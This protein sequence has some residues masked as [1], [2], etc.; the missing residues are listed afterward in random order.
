LECDDG[1]VHEITSSV[2]Q[3]TAQ[4]AMLF[5][6]LRARL[7]GV[8]LRSPVAGLRL[9][10][11][12][13]EDGGLQMTLFSGSDPDPDAL[14]IAIARLDAALGE[15]H[16]LRA[17]VVDGPRIERRFVFEPFTLEVLT[18]KPPRAVPAVSALPDT[19]TFQYRI[20]AP[21]PIDVTLGAGLPRFVGSPAQAVLDVAGPWRIDE[22]WWTPATG[23]GV[24]LARDE[25]DV[26][27][28]DG[29]LLRGAD[30]LAGIPGVLIH[31]RHDMGGPL[32]TAWELARAWPDAELVAVEDAGHTGS[33]TMRER[34]RSA[35]DK[36]ARQ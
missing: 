10:A 11:E 22:G 33:D 2:A 5:E 7:E 3:P 13:L 20:V 12:R 15:R 34:I 4:P 9:C 35:L 1:D 36:F 24:P 29:A 19:A 32:H 21:A 27:L 31:G 30:R 26:L 28:E 18:G 14:G 23:G 6:L 17:R 25:Y 16:A 8:V